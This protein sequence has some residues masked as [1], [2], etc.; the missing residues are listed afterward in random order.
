MLS[1]RN[2]HSLAVEESCELLAHELHALLLEA[3][4]RGHAEGIY[5]KLRPLLVHQQIVRAHSFLTVLA[6]EGRGLGG[7]GSHRVLI[8]GGI[9]TLQV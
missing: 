3:K 8:D 9:L 6:H 7:E 2:S 5:D 4:A 1:I